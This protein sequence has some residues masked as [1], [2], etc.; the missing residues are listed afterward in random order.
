VATA[1]QAIVE[2]ALA[3]TLIFFLLAAAVDLGLI[4][5]TLQGLNNAAQE[6]AAFG[7]R[8]LAIQEDNTQPN[9]GDQIVNQNEIRNRVRFESGTGGGIN[10]VN[11]FDLD[12]DGVPDVTD[13]MGDPVRLGLDGVPYSYDTSPNGG[14]VYTDYI[15]INM[16]GYWDQDGDGSPELG[17]DDDCLGQ[18]V[19]TGRRHPCFLQ[20]AVSYE[21]DLVFGLAPAFGDRVRLTQSHTER[22]VDPLEKLGEVI[23]GQE[24]VFWTA[25]AT[26]TPSP[27]N[28]PTETPSPTSSPTVG[29]SPTETTTPPII[30]STPTET[31]TPGPSPTATNTHT[32]GPSPTATD[33]PTNT[34]TPTPTPSLFI[35]W[36]DPDEER[37]DPEDVVYW[38]E[39]DVKDVR[40]A[41]DT[42]F[43]VVAYGFNAEDDLSGMTEHQKDGTNIDRVEFEI[44]G[45]ADDRGPGEQVLWRA[46]GAP[47][48]PEGRAGFCVFGGNTPCNRLNEAPDGRN[49]VPDWRSFFNGPGEYTLRSRAYSDGGVRTQWVERK[50]N[51]LAAEDMAVWIT[52]LDGDLLDEDKSDQ[53]VPEV[54]TQDQTGFRAVAYR[55]D[56]DSTD[57]DLG[58]DGTDVDRVEV[59]ILRVGN[60]TVE[61][62]QN[63]E[64][65][66]TTRFFPRRKDGTADYHFFSTDNHLMSDYDFSRLDTGIYILRARTLGSNSFLWSEWTETL[67]QVPPIDLYIEFIDPVPPSS[68][69]RDLDNPDLETAIAETKVIST[70][71]DT[72]FRAI[73]YD[74]S[75][76]DPTD[77]LEQR[78]AKDG[79][80]ISQVQFELNAPQD[81]PF[82]DA[83]TDY[84]KAFCTEGPTGADL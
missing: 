20:V 53:T 17:V 13:D 55:K 48:G 75:E 28:T 78:I 2:F 25:T 49:E 57:Y 10:A 58:R 30:T 18:T 33:T 8:W 34:P 83:V 23:P 81:F 43:R 14:A 21:Y 39:G 65:A 56:G 9:F 66:G 54:D 69:P 47:W 67:V 36:V 27:T 80:N 35:A 46:D 11:L 45:P 24:P 1:G 41:D 72:Q 64:Y 38:A 51:V 63:G 73:A 29:P 3:A 6:G 40:T 84:K 59:E 82:R 37:A 12:N 16:L 5:F 68:N 61:Q 7:A 76:Y 31:H 79:T 32:P 77:T 62:V 4:F 60:F 22:I 42:Y 70:L 15:R 26:N 50:I 74:L 19:S 52:N 44:R 71:Q